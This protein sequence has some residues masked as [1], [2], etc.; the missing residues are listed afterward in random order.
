ME[1]RPLLVAYVVVWALYVASVHILA[2][3]RSSEHLAGA[4]SHAAPSLVALAMGA[5]FLVGGGATV[6]QLSGG[7]EGRSLWSIWV[8]L[9]PQLLIITLVAGIANFVALT[10]CL[11][12]GNIGRYRVF[13]FASGCVMCAFACVTVFFNFPSA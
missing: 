5:I 10:S 7:G 8:D 11:F 2:G 9:W 13:V 12:R 1:N 4:A 3:R 6:A